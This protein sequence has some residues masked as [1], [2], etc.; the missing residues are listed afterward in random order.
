GAFDFQL[1]NRAFEIGDTDHRLRHDALGE[2][3]RILHDQLRF[4]ARVRL[5]ILGNFLRGEQ[6]VFENA[7]ALRMIVEILAQ[8]AVLARETINVAEQALDLFGNETEISAHFVD[9]IALQ[10][11]RESLLLNLERSQILHTPSR[12]FTDAIQYKPRRPA[13]PSTS[14]WMRKII[15]SSSSGDQSM[16]AVSK[17]RR[18][19]RNGRRNGHVSREKISLSCVRTLYAPRLRQRNDVCDAKKRIHE[20]ITHTSTV[21]RMTDRTIRRIRMNGTTIALVI[22]ACR[23]SPVRRERSSLLLRSRSRSLRSCPSTAPA[24]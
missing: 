19:L 1:L 12:R 23:R 7:F 15:R 18:N 11:T 9:V 5:H 21:Q 6:R 22:R 13:I 24:I 10:R 2:E 17:R 14:H 4:F 3:L 20:R 16:P 8:H